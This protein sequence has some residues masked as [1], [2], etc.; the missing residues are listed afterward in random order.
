[1]KGENKLADNKYQFIIFGGTGDLAQRKLLPAFYNLKAQGELPDDF[2]IVATGR[3]YDDETV[4]L[5][6]MYKDV[7]KYSRFDIDKEI[8]DSLAQNISYLKFD[9]KGDSGYKKLK[10]MLTDQKKK[11][12]YLAVAPEFFGPIIEK[13]AKYNIV[14]KLSGDSRLVI[15][16]PFGQDLETAKKLNEQIR[17]VFPEKNIFRIDHYLGKEM[18]QN[19][20]FIRF[21]NIFFEPVWN[22]KYI[23]N[24]QIISS[25]KNGV[26][27]R[28][29]YYDQAGALKDMM[30]NHMLQ[31]LTLTAMEPPAVM[32]T[33]SIRNEKVKILKSLESIPEDNTKDY[34]VRGQYGS[35]E[36][37][38]ES[39]KGY[40]EEEKVA[41]GSSTETFVAIKA[42]IDNLRWSGV[43][44]YIKT[45][46]RLP[47]KYTEII[48]EFN[49]SFHPSYIKQFPE[50]KS[51][52]LVIKIQPLEGVYIQFN[53]KEPG[54]QDKIV[55]VQ[56]DFCQNCQESANSPEAY[57]RLIY[58][59]I[60]GDTT[61]FTRWDE[62]KYS[63]EYI[64]KI[65]EAWQ[66][67][68]PDFPN[69]TSG[70]KGP[71]AADDLLAQDDR[72]WLE[73]DGDLSEWV[74]NN[75]VIGGRFNE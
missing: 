56:M 26:G 35:G 1:M 53:A 67:I 13:I 31:L 47:K 68:E 32:D 71:K 40:R 34:V 19:I 55:P 23:D 57:E 51:N 3:R 18:L 36:I 65:T 12:F 59:I 64:D 29:G 9:L 15:E 7:Q 58:D 11:I 24:V 17:K 49:S 60:K 70:S 50:L 69:Y 8:W 72:E 74:N 10:K 16:K 4:Y 30:Q 14:E 33:E 27:E 62:V 2:S 38:G 48:I 5:E 54:T 20:L 37:D 21:S 61:L 6:N 66:E 46:K 22:N 73:V 43:P 41:E 39:V 52:L 25:E 63:W 44:F 42:H 45:G 75:N 28:G